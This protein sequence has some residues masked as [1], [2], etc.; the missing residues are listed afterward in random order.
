MKARNLFLAPA[1]LVLAVAAAPASPASGSGGLA[2]GTP[3]LEDSA[4]PEARQALAVDA[5][6]ASSWPC[7]HD[8]RF[9]EFDFWIGEW[10]V[11]TPD[12]RHAGTNVIER[13]QRGCL[14]IEHWTSAVQGSG[15]SFNYVDRESGEWVQLWL[16]SG[17][18]QI[19]IRGG[20]T[21]EGMLLEG[22]IL[23]VDGA[24]APFRGLWTLLPD[25]RIRQFFEQSDDGGRT[26]SP[27]F[28]GY[29]SRTEGGDG[30]KEAA[31][32]R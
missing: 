14:L 28:E 26:W 9:R 18:R 20:L 16:D 23:Q 21:E 3:A 17:G 19:E 32:E 12:N 30:R 7:E 1:M 25:G 31:K 29:Y 4:D 6:A 8:G 10:Q 2:A 27:W 15:T 5:Q 22:R 24:S 13:A 11:E